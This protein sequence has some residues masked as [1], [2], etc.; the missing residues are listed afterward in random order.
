MF[1]E[2]GEMANNICFSSSIIRFNY[3][4]FKAEKKGSHPVFSETSPRQVWKGWE[5]TEEPFFTRV[6]APWLS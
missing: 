1:S 5:A 4:V 6:A 2:G 3:L